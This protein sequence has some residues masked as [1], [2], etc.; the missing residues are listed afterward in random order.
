M[1]LSYP[2]VRN[3]CGEP[4][5][6]DIDG[7]LSSTERHNRIF[8]AKEEFLGISPLFPERNDSIHRQSQW[9]MA[10]IN[11]VLFLRIWIKTT[12]VIAM[13]TKNWMNRQL[14]SESDHFSS[15]WCIVGDDL[16]SIRV[17]TLIENVFE[18]FLLDSCLFTPFSIYAS[19]AIASSI[20]TEIFWQGSERYCL[21]TMEEYDL[22]MSTDQCNWEFDQKLPWT[23]SEFPF[24]TLLP[25]RDWSKMLL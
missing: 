10:I 19:A 8:S 21:W 16:S 17:S 23:K 18:H 24:R 6:F 11:L 2:H 3:E 15:L 25:K 7:F 5:F 12:I 22:M 1:V 14:V 9:M 20:D 4:F 13:K